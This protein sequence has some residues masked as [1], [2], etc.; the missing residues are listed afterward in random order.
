MSRVSVAWVIFGS[1][2]T[3]GTFFPFLPLRGVGFETG[4]GVGF[5]IGFLQAWSGR[6]VAASKCV[7]GNVSAIVQRLQ[8]MLTVAAAHRIPGPR[9]VDRAVG[10]MLGSA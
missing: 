2:L 3:R 7:C 4:F 1:S 8:I 6:V 10:P 5:G 9:R